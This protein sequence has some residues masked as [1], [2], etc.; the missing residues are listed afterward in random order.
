MLKTEFFDRG[1]AGEWTTFKMALQNLLVIG[2]H[3]NKETTPEH[4]CSSLNFPAHTHIVC[5]GFNEE[6]NNWH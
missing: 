1:E 2:M 4:R 3:S 5:T 6:Q